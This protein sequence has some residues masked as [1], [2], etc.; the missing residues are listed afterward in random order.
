MHTI[1]YGNKSIMAKWFSIL[2]LVSGFT[3]F[4]NLDAQNQECITNFVNFKIIVK[5]YKLK[6]HQSCKL[7]AYLPPLII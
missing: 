7:K 4:G 2:A 3:L 6:P 1:I 5:S